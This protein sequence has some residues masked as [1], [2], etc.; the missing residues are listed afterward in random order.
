MGLQCADG[1]STGR[2]SVLAAAPLKHLLRREVIVGEE[3]TFTVLYFFMLPFKCIPPTPHPLTGK[4]REYVCFFFNLSEGMEV[5]RSHLPRVTEVAYRG[6]LQKD[7]CAVC[8][9]CPVEVSVCAVRAGEFAG[10]SLGRAM[11]F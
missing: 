5:Q 4:G 11:T 8:T 9:H 1:G 10:S 3:D 7:R 6:D 2:S